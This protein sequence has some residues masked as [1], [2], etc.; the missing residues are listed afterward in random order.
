METYKQMRDRQQAEFNM[1][2]IK[3]AFNMEQFERNMAEWGLTKDDTDK[4]S[5]IP[6]GGFALKTDIPAIKECLTR[7]TSEFKEAV[8]ADKD[9]T[10]FIKSMFLHELYNH[11]YG[12]TLEIEDTLEALGYSFEDIESNEALKRGLRDARNHIHKKENI[13]W[14]VE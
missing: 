6:Y 4:I 11:E 14:V 3:F 13:S 7:H 8:A 10:G 2:P 1:L 12:Y 5:K 9:G